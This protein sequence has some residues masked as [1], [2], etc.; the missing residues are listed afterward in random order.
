M[1]LGSGVGGCS[2]WTQNKY[3]QSAQNQIFVWIETNTHCQWECLK[4]YGENAVSTIWSQQQRFSTNIHLLHHMLAWPMVTPHPVAVNGNKG[5]P[6][7]VF[8]FPVS[9]RNGMLFNSKSNLDVIIA[10]E[11][12]SAGWLGR[13]P[14]KVS[15]YK[16]RNQQDGT[17]QPHDLDQKKKKKNTKVWEK[18][19]LTG[20]KKTT[21][22]C[23]VPKYITGFLQSQRTCKWERS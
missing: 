19:S 15:S 10:V 22:A 1:L 7:H 9:E 18:V 8:I 3:L 12:I 23:W 6:I 4:A 13:E 14:E 2:G 16:Q 17:Q 21:F 11:R 20:M 5:F